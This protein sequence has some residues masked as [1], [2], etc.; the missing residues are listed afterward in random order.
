MDRK[1]E[2][3]Y[4]TGAFARYFGIK[5]D[6]LFYYDQI[7]LFSPAAVGKN[8]YRYYNASQIPPFGTLLSLREMNVPIEKIRAYFEAPSPEKLEEMAREQIGL[9]KRKSAGGRKFKKAFRR[10]WRRRRKGGLL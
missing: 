7:G 10:F 8:G 3:L 5:K 1:E 4:T 6:T 2:K 9:L